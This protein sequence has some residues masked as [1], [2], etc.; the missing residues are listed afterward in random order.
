MNLKQS[1][2]KN[3]RVYLSIEK[4]YRDKVTGNPKARTIQS[5]GYLDE[6]EKEYQD[7]I[8]HFKEVAR[9]MTDEENNKKKL[10]LTFNMD[11]QLVQGTDDRK[12]LGYA[13]I[14]KIYHE[15]GLH[16]FLNNRARNEDFKFN[17]NSI[18]MLLVIS[19]LLSPGSKKKTFEEKGRYFERFNFS[20]PDVYRALSH[21]AKIAKD[22]QQFLNEQITEKY[23]RDTKTVYYDVT[24]FYFEID[25]PDEVRKFGPSKEKR[26]NPIIQMGLAMDANGIPLHYELFPGNKLDKETFRSVIG[27][28]RKN[29]DTGRIVV[30]ADMGII[31]GDNIYYL[32]GGKNR[33]GYVFS[34][35]V[36]GATNEFKNYVLDNEGYAGTNGKPAGEDAE[37]KIKS[38][39]IAREINVTMKS[40]KKAKKTVYEKQVVFW[41]KKYAVKAKAEREELV[42]KALDLVA[43]PQ[44]YNKA[45]SYGAARYIKHLEF[46]KNTGEIFEGKKKPYFDDNKLAEHEMYDGYY[47]IVTSEMQMT[48]GEIIDTYRGLWEIEE[49]FKVTKGTLEARPVY[50]SREDRIEAHYLT[51]F[52]AL[53][54]I[55]L[56]QKKMD[57][58]YSPKMIIE[59][60]NKIASS[61]E[62]DNLYLFDYRSEISDDIG[63]VLGIDFTRK[64]LRLADIKNILANCKK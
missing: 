29:Y 13:A 48:D 7:P 49:T 55:R 51:C 12:N 43:N 36:R 40:G 17:T 30:V 18:M 22:L 8:A 58:R 24:N 25:K 59:C 15:L 37:F 5:I 26:P 63:N 32:T 6:L 27:E 4:S 16:R 23:G 2:R 60:L 54:I 44:K 19:R 45:T 41:S 42:K 20:L 50:V 1:R 34:F 14:L 64:R 33:N 21:Y 52:I 28:V 31:T 46:N 57:R 56:I 9:K 35:S 11:E 53:V 61:N 38:R 62:Q 39:R 10:T 3:G 47:A